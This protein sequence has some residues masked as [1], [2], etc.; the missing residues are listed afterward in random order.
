MVAAA[1]ARASG[2]RRTSVSP[3]RRISL[4]RSWIQPVM[5]L[6][7]GPPSGG[8]YLKPPSRGGLCDGV[9]T[10]PSA[11][12]SSAGAVPV[13]P[14]DRVRHGGGRRV[15][16]PVVDEHGDVVGREHLERGRPGR[17]G[18]PVGVAPE[19]QRA[20]H[21]GRGAVLDDRLAGGGDVVL[22]EREVQRRATVPGGAEGDLLRRLGHVGMTGVVGRDERGDVDEVGSGG[23]LA[24]P[25]V[26]AHGGKR[27]RLPG[28]LARGG[29][30]RCPTGCS[31]SPARTPS[32]CRTT[33]TW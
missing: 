1:R 29:E 22:V 2:T 15:A 10:T 11:R 30:A 3:P 26:G 24:S 19:E 7:A 18:E 14:Q 27:G 8:L 13:V 21:A 16:V 20:G 23:G 9:T 32:R 25:R 12:G 31:T 33:S 4:A 17:L 5:S 28:L 6:P